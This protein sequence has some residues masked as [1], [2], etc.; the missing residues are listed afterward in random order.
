MS[1]ARA[2]VDIVD[3]AISSVSGLT[4]QPSL[5]ALVCA[6]EGTEREP[7]VNIDSLQELSDYWESVR[8]WYA[9]FESGLLAPSS[10]VY[11][12]EIPGGQYS[13][14]KPQAFSVGLAEQWPEVRDRY[15]EVNFALGDVIKV[16]PSS[17][18]VG[19]F[20]LWLV[21]NNTTVAEL[22]NQ[23]GQPD[24]PASVTGF[25]EGAIGIP[26]GGFPEA[27]RKKVLGENA[28]PA[29]TRGATQNMAPYD[30]AKKREELSKLYQGPI[31]DMLEISYALYPKVIRDYLAFITAHGDVSVVDTETFFYGLDENREITIE[32]EPGKSLIVTRAALSEMKED[33]T[34]MVHFL[35]NGQPRSAVVIDKKEAVSSVQR[36]KADVTDNTHV[37]AP[38]PGTVVR[39]DV[40]AGDKVEKGDALLVLEAMKLE[41]TVKAPQD[42]VVDKALVAT[43]DRLEAG[44]LVFVIK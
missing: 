6:L 16:T 9:P 25:F 41:T 43:G 44:D 7:D 3:G 2:G 24:L 22:M 20:A 33:G 5:N 8:T 15:R 19:D 37:G 18:V 4:S 29:P 40:K 17:K 11:K 28:G 12:H 10:D 32:L 26:E 14:L 42:G 30:F 1:A 36:Q 35:L 13:N 38:M 31:T 23:P 34:R 39:I 27:L 21:S